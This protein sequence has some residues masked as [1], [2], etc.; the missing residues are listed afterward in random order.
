M[1]HIAIKAASSSLFRQR[2]GAAVIKNG[3]VLSTACN[4]VRYKRGRFIKRWENSLHA[5][6]AALLMLPPKHRK[7][8]SLYVARLLRDGSINNACPCEVCRDLII[9]SGVKEVFYTNERGDVVRWKP[10]RL[11]QKY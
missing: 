10:I 2:V 8:S 3:N 9:N 4:A 5:E 11:N 6:Q 7:G 1:I